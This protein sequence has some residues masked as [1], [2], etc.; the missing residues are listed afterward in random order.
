MAPKGLNA[1]KETG[2]AKKAENALK[3]KEESAAE[4]VCHVRL[5]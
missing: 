2:K 3:Q 4:K 1:K 5:V